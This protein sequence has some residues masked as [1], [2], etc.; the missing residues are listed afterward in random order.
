VVI[1]AEIARSGIRGFL[2]SAFEQLSRVLS[3]KGIPA[4]GP[5]FARY[6]VNELTFGVTAGIPVA[7]LPA[8]TGRMRVGGIPG[9]LIASTIHVGSY[10][11]LPHAFHAVIQW[12]A[13]AGYRI[14]ADP[15]ESYLDGPDVPHPRTEVCFPVARGSEGE[16]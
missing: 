10:D 11:E 14:A 1:E 8:A 9:G 7:R 12:A 13:G 4:Q 3:E 15:W 5:P 2:S 6:R 16:P